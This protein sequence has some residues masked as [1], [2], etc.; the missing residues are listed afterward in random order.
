MKRLFKHNHWIRFIKD[1]VVC[2]GVTRTFV[3]TDKYGETKTY[4]YIDYITQ[5]YDYY[6]NKSMRILWEDVTM[7]MLPTY[8]SFSDENWEKSKEIIKKTLNKTL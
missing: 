8:I 5:E 1:G 7:D 6:D 3:D 2:F 4:K